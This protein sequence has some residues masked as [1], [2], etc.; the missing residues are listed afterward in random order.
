V[1]VTRFE[2]LADLRE[3]MF[4]YRAELVASASRIASDRL[5]ALEA[6][7]PPT[8]SELER[9]ADLYGVDADAL[10]EQSIEIGAHDALGVLALLAEFRDVSST[11]RLRIVAAANA[12]RD[13]VA[14]R[15]LLRERRALDALRA[16]HRPAP[17]QAGKPPHEQGAHW[18]RA[19][20]GEVGLASRPIPSVRDLVAEAFPEI[21]VLHADLG[22]D[23]LSGVSFADA[24]RGPTIVLN[25]RG[26][27]GNPLVR[28]FSLLHELAH[29]LV[30]LSRREPLAVLS[31]FKQEAHLAIEQRAN[32]FAV[33]FICPEKKLREIAASHAPLAAA[34]EL[35]ERW[36]LHFEAARLY[37]D[38]VAHVEV[39]RRATERLVAAS[40]EG[41]WREAEHTG[42]DD[43]P[44]PA[45][46]PE[47]RTTVAQLAASAYSR[48]KIGRDRF[49]RLLGLTPADD[50]ERV[51]GFFALDP[52]VGD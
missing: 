24:Q 30:D 26:K 4:G 50:L 12:A 45:V 42:L 2:G 40:V 25:L 38:R 34:A 36:G 52:P 44:V 15:A 6:G 8:V 9:L 41:R 5:A 3:R 13:V 28:R 39:P 47:R 20:R 17:P 10:A 7:E 19:W 11:T 48:G 22:D 31:G 46:L 51:L 21:T 33:R 1:P 32:A 43:F 14:L 27:N 35:G 37:L 49:S 29:L 16:R 18:A 23:A